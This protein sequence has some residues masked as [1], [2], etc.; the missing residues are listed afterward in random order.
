MELFSSVATNTDW[1]CRRREVGKT[2]WVSPSPCRE[3]TPAPADSA[4]GKKWC[5]LVPCWSYHF[6]SPYLLT[7]QRRL[8]C[9]NT[10]F[11]GTIPGHNKRVSER[12]PVSSHLHAS[13]FFLYVLNSQRI[14][15]CLLKSPAFTVQ[16]LPQLR[17]R[18]RTSLRSFHQSISQ[19]ERSDQ[20][21]NLNQEHA[22]GQR[23]EEIPRPLKQPT[24]G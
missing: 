4:L 17:G 2:L 12:L 9:K 3:T 20:C 21:D 24:H 1:R 13:R 16:Q 19:T 14:G 5:L 8:V 10:V 23:R 7:A 22:E 15:T 6:I 11:R 18:S